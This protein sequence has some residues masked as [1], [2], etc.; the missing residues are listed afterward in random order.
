MNISIGIVGLGY[1][2]NA[3]REGFSDKYDIFSYDIN[4][5]GTEKDLESV[6]RKAD[7]ICLRSNPNAEKWI[8]S[9]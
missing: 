7:Y 2:G 4:G 1:V 3:V 5:N 8:M 9:H 6:V